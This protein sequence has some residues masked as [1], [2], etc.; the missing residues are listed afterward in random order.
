[1]KNFKIKK[2]NN[3]SKY[4]PSLTCKSNISGFICFKGDFSYDI[5]YKQIDSNKLIG[6]SDAIHHHISS[7]RLGWRWRIDLNCIEIVTIQYKNTSRKIE[8][9]TYVYENIELSFSIS[10][11]NNYYEVE[12]GGITKI[13]PKSNKYNFIRYKLYPYFGGDE[14]APKEFNIEIYE[15]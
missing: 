2:G 4:L 14:S 11:K 6:L 10:I 8:H 15:K 9:L 12:I 3:R 7:I 5:G 1:M 13:I